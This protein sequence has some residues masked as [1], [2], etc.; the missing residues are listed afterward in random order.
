M[1]RIFDNIAQHLLPTIRKTLEDATRADFC[2]GYFNLRGWKLIDDWSTVG[3]G[4]PTAE[5]GS[6][7]ACNGP[8]RTS[9]RPPSA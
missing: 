7:S 2:V 8:P 9:S 4:P 6:S 1:P 3:R 5:A